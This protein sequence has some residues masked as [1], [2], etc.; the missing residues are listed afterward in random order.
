MKSHLKCV[1]IL[2]FAALTALPAWGQDLTKSG[3]VVFPAERVPAVFPA[4]AK[5][6]RPAANAGVYTIVT[7]PDLR[8]ALLLR[9]PLKGQY[10]RR[11]KLDRELPLDGLDRIDRDIRVA[12]V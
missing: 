11:L 12:V 4:A 5:G 6:V 3:T 9:Q 8:G 2:I 7:T 1:S 10:V